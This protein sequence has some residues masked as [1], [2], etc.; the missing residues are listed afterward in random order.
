MQRRSG[1]P[2]MLLRWGMPGERRLGRG[3]SEDSRA[4]EKILKMMDLSFEE[5]DVEGWIESGEVVFDVLRDKG[6]F[7]HPAEGGFGLVVL[8]GECTAEA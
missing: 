4:K 7:E 6:M 3:P 8:S 2:R 1:S 5:D